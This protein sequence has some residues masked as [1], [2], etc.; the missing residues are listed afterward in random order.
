MTG[1][2]G[3]GNSVV[4]LINKYNNAKQIQSVDWERHSDSDEPN[5]FGLSNTPN[6]CNQPAQYVSSCNSTPYDDSR[7]GWRNGG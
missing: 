2:E 5:T 7:Q 1:N 3:N 4:F 6:L